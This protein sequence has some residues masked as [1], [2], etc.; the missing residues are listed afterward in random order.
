MIEKLV[1]STKKSIHDPIEI[2]IDN[3]TYF[4]RPLSHALFDEIKK[5]QAET[6]KDDSEKLVKQILIIYDVP[7]EIVNKLDVRDLVSMLKYTT[8]KM[9]ELRKKTVEE[10]AEKNASKSGDKK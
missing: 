10:T 8:G 7:F 4:S 5:R 1:L 2:V 6:G 9:A 3:K